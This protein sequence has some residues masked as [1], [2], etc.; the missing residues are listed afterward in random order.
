M[1]VCAPVHIAER[2]SMSTG[3]FGD[4]SGELYLSLQLSKMTGVKEVRSD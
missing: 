1:Y 3:G 2:V 4:M